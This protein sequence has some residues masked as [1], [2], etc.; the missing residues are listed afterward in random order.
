MKSFQKVNFDQILDITTQN[1]LSNWVQNQTIQ[2]RKH[3]EIGK[4]ENWKIWKKKKMIL[5]KLKF[6][7]NWKSNSSG[8]FWRNGKMVDNLKMG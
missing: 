1:I 3:G 5:G 7:Q 8:K 6:G 4:I 2:I